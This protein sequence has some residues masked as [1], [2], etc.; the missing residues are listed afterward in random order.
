M[1][2]LFSTTQ[3]AFLKNIQNSEAQLNRFFSEHWEY[4]F[5]QYTFIK[6]EFPLDGIVRT[7][8]SRGRIDILAFNPSS[9]KFVVFELKRDYSKNIKSQADDYRYAIIRDFHKIHNSCTDDWDA[10][11]PRP[12]SMVQDSI[13]TVLIAGVF[14]PTDIEMV[15]NFKSDEITLIKYSWFENDLLLIEY[16]NIKP[17]ESANVGLS[18]K[19]NYAIQEKTNP[20][21]SDKPST[22]KEANP[23]RTNNP[24]TIL[25]ISLNGR[26]L[27]GGI[28]T[29]IG[30]I[31]EWGIE[32]V[33]GIAKYV[34][35]DDGDP[36]II[37]SSQFEESYKGAKKEKRYKRINDKYYIYSNTGT[38]RKKE[39]L[40]KIAT[41][42]N[43]KIE[44]EI[45]PK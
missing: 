24:D 37:T 41:Q 4:F 32:R 34:K 18:S 29:F 20:V 26:V 11:I 38:D 33:R 30:V 36:L 25:K 28:D 12:K 9:N 15:N 40:E 14:F 3:R 27:Q 6:S 17:V 23:K 2:K 42:L 19:T 7:S 43:E 10:R 22:Q 8:G 5:P 44:V 45:I 39:W 13:E 1:V 31:Q 16:L 35:P 21:S